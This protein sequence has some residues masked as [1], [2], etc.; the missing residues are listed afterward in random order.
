MPEKKILLVIRTE[1]K[2]NKMTFQILKKEKKS[3]NFAEY[4]NKRV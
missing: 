3:R 4:E 2:S 1:L